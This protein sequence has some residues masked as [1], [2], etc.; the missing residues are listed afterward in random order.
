VA[1]PTIGLAV[2]WPRSL[3]GTNLTDAGVRNVLKPRPLIACLALATAL[4]LA[5]ADVAIASLFLIFDRTSGTQGTV[6]HVHT[7]GNGACV[8]C[9]HRMPL[10]FAQAA[11]S[12]GI[13]SPGDSRLTQVGRH[14]LGPA[15][16]MERCS[17]TPP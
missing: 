6:V 2:Y 5:T 3:E 12:D 15:P 8:V 9:P 14:V 7:G 17:H 1:E 16:G 4:L 13:G 10:Y 11:I